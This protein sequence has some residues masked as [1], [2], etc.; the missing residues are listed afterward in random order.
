MNIDKFI[1]KRMFQFGKE[2]IQ[3]KVSCTITRTPGGVLKFEL[4]RGVP[5]EPL[6]PYPSLKVI[7][8]K[9]GTHF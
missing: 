5:L 7:L 4:D 9:K 2:D 1:L 6:N 3:Y 8:D